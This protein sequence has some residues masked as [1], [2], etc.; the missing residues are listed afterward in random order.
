MNLQSSFIKP[1][2]FG[3]LQV[4]VWNF[5]VKTYGHVANREGA[6]FSD[7]EGVTFHSKFGA[8]T[9]PLELKSCRRCHS[10]DGIRNQLTAQNAGTALFLVKN[11]F[12]PPFP[13]RANADDIA[14]LEKLVLF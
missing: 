2:L 7:G 6:S 12:M 9:R 11:G 3:R 13:F 4:V 14:M 8:L 1:S 5:R 10:S